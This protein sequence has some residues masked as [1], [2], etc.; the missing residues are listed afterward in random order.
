MAKHK[1]IGSSFDDFLEEE[2]IL[3]ECKRGLKGASAAKLI[4]TGSPE[5][6][7]PLWGNFSGQRPFKRKR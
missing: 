4:Y 7:M 3:E 6:R 5:D 2:G 1:H